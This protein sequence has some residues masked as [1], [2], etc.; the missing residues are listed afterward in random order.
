[1]TK[2]KPE[3]SELEK[4]WEAEIAAEEAARESGESSAAAEAM[5]DEPAHEQPEGPSAEEAWNAEREQLT[6]Q[7]LRARA[8]FDNYRKRTARDLERIRKTAAEA[9]IRD[10]LPVVDHLELALRHA[11]DAESGLAEGV[12]LVL[13]QFQDV[14]QKQGLREI[15]AVGCP[16]D[17]NIH[18]ALMQREDLDVPLHTVLEAFQKGYMLGE[19]VL[20]PAKVIVS[21][22]GPEREVGEGEASDEGSAGLWESEENTVKANVERPE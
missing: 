16:F 20:R 3:K 2:K 8:E 5:E 4:R 18:E 15:P 10:L 12:D 11:E 17:P 21:S 6:D 14:L 22:G 9:L 19:M 1:M 13:K 7:I